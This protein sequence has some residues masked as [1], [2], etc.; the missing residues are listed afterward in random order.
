MLC[1][2]LM[3][4]SM[5]VTIPVF[6]H[7]FKESSSGLRNL[8]FMMMVP[9]LAML[10]LGPFIG[11]LEDRYGKRPFL[12]LGF[13]GLVVA[14]IGFLC[15]HAA[16][17]YI[18]LRLFQAVASVGI[19]PAMMGM[20]ADVVP[21][22]QRTH[23]ISLMMTGSA[24][25]MTLGPV[26][27]GF[28]LT[29]WGTI[30]PFGMAALLNFSVL[31]VVCIILPKV[32][33]NQP[34]IQQVS[35]RKVAVWR[36][37]RNMLI[38]FM[39]PLSFLLGLLLLDFV[40]AFG[41][42]FVAP[43]RALYLYKVLHLTPMQFG[44]LTSTHGLSMLLGLIA[45]S[46]W[47]EK[48]NKRTTIV[49]GF[50]SHAFLI[51]SLLFVHQFSSLF[52]I[53]LFAGIGGGMVRPLLSAYY[54]DRTTPE[55]RSSLIGIKEAVTALGEIAGSLTVVLASAWLIPHRTFLLGGSIIVIASMIAFIILK[56]HRI[57]LPSP[58][59]LAHAIHTDEALN[60]MLPEV[61]LATE[62]ICPSHE[63]TSR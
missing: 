9:H 51:F 8:S 5:G 30:A 48:T 35:R 7:L 11:E 23:R 33:T 46:L 42:S 20:F 54:L 29:H 63:S 19:M 32:F 24:G 39:V 57:A 49:L 15:V 10:I 6:A 43:Q 47:G 62:Q 22:Q 60:D 58:T 16:G 26:M 45:L 17:A 1:S 41:Q 2:L 34:C 52:L 55:H 61:A 14:D 40:S 18:G 44:L 25:G 3:S 53:S 56:S 28:L 12:L 37:S 31:C 59:I 50:L 4:T 27:G 13:V 38:P 36:P 21:S